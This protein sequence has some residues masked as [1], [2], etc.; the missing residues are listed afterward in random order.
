[1][2]A[3]APWKC[4]IG[5]FPVDKM[6]GK[7][8]AQLVNIALGMAAEAGLR[9]WSI[10]TDGNTVNTTMFP[11]RGCKFTSSFATMA[12]KFKHPTEDYYV[13]A[14]LDPCHMLKLA[15]TSLGHRTSFVDRNNNLIIWELFQSLNTIQERVYCCRQVVTKAYAF[16]KHKMNVK[17]A[18]QKLS[19]SVANS[20]E[21]LDTTTKLGTFQDS[22]GAVNFVRTTECLFDILNSRNPMVRRFK[23]P[24]RPQS[25]E[26]WHE[27]LVATADQLLSL[28]TN[29]TVQ[30]PLVI[31]PRKTFILDF[32]TCIKSVIEMT[33]EMFTVINQPFKYFLTYKF[34]Q[35][36]LE[37]LFSCI[38]AKGCWNNNP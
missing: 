22:H 10:T 31:H 16:G 13:Y 17:L 3:R 35:D 28:K 27:I 14:I 25:K 19:S 9:I 6:S 33:H 4:P 30:Q 26:T 8:Q 32:V 15:S 18:A 7:T 2:S 23:Q 20:I 38:R 36:H 24:L 5:Y 1:M 11:E 21:F 37:L 34:S 12:T 29:T